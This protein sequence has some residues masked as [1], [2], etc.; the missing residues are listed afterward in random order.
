MAQVL[1]SHWL[2]AVIIGYNCNTS[3]NKSNH[4]IKNA[5]LFVTEPRTRDNINVFNPAISKSLR[6]ALFYLI[7]IFSTR[8]EPE[9]F[10]VYVI[11]TK[12]CLFLNSYPINF[13][14]GTL[15]MKMNSKSILSSFWLKRQCM[16]TPIKCTSFLLRLKNVEFNSSNT[17]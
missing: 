7:N 8:I 14:E 16:N 13:Q 1:D 9:T 12:I 6:P 3:T 11:H 4:P 10:T 17:I 5:L 2:W 15:F